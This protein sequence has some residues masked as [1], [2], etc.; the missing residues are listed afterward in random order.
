MK[1][2]SRSGHLGNGPLASGW[3]LEDEDETVWAG[4]PKLV[5][6]GV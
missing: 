2:G 6:K 5:W 1:K 4:P 3:A